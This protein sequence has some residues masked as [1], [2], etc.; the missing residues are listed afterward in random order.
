M[1]FPWDEEYCQ[2]SGHRRR[3]PDERLRELERR[4]KATNDSQ[5][6]DVY[7][8]ALDRTGAIAE[9]IQQVEQA[10]RSADDIINV[11]TDPNDL[12][13]GRLAKAGG[14]VS[15]EDYTWLAKVLGY[16]YRTGIIPIQ[17]IREELRA[18]DT[19]AMRQQILRSL[20]WATPA[21]TEQSNVSGPSFGWSTLTR[22]QADTM[23]PHVEGTF[24]LR[25]T[26]V[27]YDRHTNQEVIKFS[28][29]RIYWPVRLYASDKTPLLKVVTRKM[30]Q[31]DGSTVL[32]KVN[33]PY[34]H[35]V[36]LLCPICEV[37][38]PA[39]RIFNHFTAVDHGATPKQRRKPLSVIVDMLHRRVNKLT[40]RQE[41]DPE[42]N[43]SYSNQIYITAIPEFLPPIQAYLESLGMELS[44]EHAVAE[45]L[46]L[47]RR[48]YTFNYKKLLAER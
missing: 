22:S 20:L 29:S 19:P 1:N 10:F 32:K 30:R 17:Q 13:L 31:P 43:I 24:W 37:E 18:W 39:G 34:S 8:A 2:C 28:P 40:G 41:T 26:D 33:V 5:D 12:P 38:M 3:N 9:R 36:F 21:T 35:R 48:R 23:K 6:W 44:T 15:L 16:R 42:I 14:L 25:V 45:D 47:P 7:L 46:L 27:T 11:F 4:A